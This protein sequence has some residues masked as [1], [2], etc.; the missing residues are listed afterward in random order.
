MC[1][2]IYQKSGNGEGIVWM[3]VSVLYF[4]PL[5]ILYVKDSIANEYGSQ[6]LIPKRGTVYIQYV[7]C[8]TKINE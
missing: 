1:L 3:L 7:L 8:K 6:H 2:S 5:R 4:F